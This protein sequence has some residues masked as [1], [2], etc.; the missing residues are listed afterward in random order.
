MWRLDNPTL[1]PRIGSLQ[2]PS[3]I[4]SRMAAW[5]ATWWPEAIERGRARCTRCQAAVSVLP[6]DRGGV[7]D[8][9]SERGWAAS[10]SACGEVMST[11]LLGLLLATPEARDLRTRHPRAFARPSRREHDR[12]VV[13]LHDEVSGAGVDAVYDEATSRPVRV[14]PVA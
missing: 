10:C 11:S 3:A 4:V 9:R 6:Y 8:V 5:A 12:L 7:G 14:V 1:A 2:R 13:G